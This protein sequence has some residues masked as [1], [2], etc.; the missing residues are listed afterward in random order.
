[1]LETAKYVNHL[2]EVIAFG[3]GI[4]INYSELHDY[5]WD[6]QSESDK[7]S[8]FERG[9]VTKTI[10]VVV[11]CSTEKQG[12]KAI[13]ELMELTEKDI[14][15][16]EPGKLFINDYYLNCYI[17]GSSKT[18]Y[19]VKKGY[20]EA[21]LELVSDQ[22]QW[23]SETKFHFQYGANGTELLTLGN[24]GQNLDY[25]YDYPYNYASTITATDIVN[26][27]FASSEFKMVLY[28]SCSNPAIYINEHKYALNTSIVGGEYITIDSK[29]KT[30]ILTKRDGTK[31]NCFKDRDKGS[32]IFEKIP[33]GSS[34]VT[35]EGLY[36]F[37]V[38]LL[39]ER[40]EPK[41]I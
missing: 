37:D 27:G 3:N 20:L 18:N 22:A 40:S 19:L 2:G 28:G 26:K 36:E 24:E 38:I 5:S 14:L 17:K 7:I 12:L 1:M 13:N 23:V 15:A 31:V 6:Y 4:Y 25:P 30:I 39:E 21:K 29:K 32:Y 35:W 34:A 8:L 9:I 33:S 11:A 41:W 10:P 16:K